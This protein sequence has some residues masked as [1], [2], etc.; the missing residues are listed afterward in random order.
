MPAIT[1]SSPSVWKASDKLEFPDAIYM[2]FNP[3]AVDASGTIW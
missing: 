2:S 1:P 3:S